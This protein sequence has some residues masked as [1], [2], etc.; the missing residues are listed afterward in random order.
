[1][2]VDFSANRDLLLAHERQLS[3]TVAGDVVDRPVLALW[4]IL[5]P[6]FFVFYFFQVKRYKKGLQDFSYNFLISR[7]RTIEKVYDAAKS[8]REVD[9]DGL[10]DVS[11]TPAEVKDD[12][13]LWVEALSAHYLVL[14]GQEGFDYADL[15][16][17][18]YPKKSGYLAVLD[19]LNRVE[20]DFNQKLASRLPGDQE[21]IE[22]V[23]SSMSQ[24][25]EK[26]RRS[27]AAEIYS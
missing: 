23:I 3:R 15:V 4:M 24:S 22:A 7:Q 19:K 26:H 10:V 25:V 13:R 12:Y 11:D 14:I 20:A 9:I 1:M 27:L 16:K 17:A 6:V 8:G 5:I 2:G 21:S 18:A